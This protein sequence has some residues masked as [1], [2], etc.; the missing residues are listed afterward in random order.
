[1]IDEP[2]Y[3]DGSHDRDVF[4]KKRTL[5]PTLTRKRCLN[6]GTDV[7]LT[8][9]PVP[10]RTHTLPSGAYLCVDLYAIENLI[11]IEKLLEQESGTRNTSTPS[12]L[13]P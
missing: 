3:D 4:D 9:G 12:Q 5:A 2:A 13:L 11:R 6:T 8:L 10:C 1:M 7:R